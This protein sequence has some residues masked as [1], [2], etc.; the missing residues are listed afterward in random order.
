MFCSCIM[1]IFVLQL[2]RNVRVLSY[3]G[4]L[5][6]VLSYGGVLYIVLS[7]GGVLYI[8]LSYGGVL[9]IVLSY[10]GALRIV[11]SYGGVLYIVLSYGGVLCIV[12]SYGGVLYIVPSYGEVL[13][14]VLS[15][16]ECCPSG[17]SGC[18]RSKGFPQRLAG[19]TQSLTSDYDILGAISPEAA[20]TL[21][22][23]AYNMG[24]LVL[25]SPHDYLN[26]TDITYQRIAPFHWEHGIRNSPSYSQWPT[27]RLTL[28]VKFSPPAIVKRPEHV[29]MTVIVSC[30][31]NMG[32]PLMSKWVSVLYSGISPVRID[33]C[34]VE[35]LFISQI[36]GSWLP[37]RSTGLFLRV[38]IKNMYKPP[39]ERW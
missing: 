13:Y 35:L 24:G 32:I 15:M 23:E 2:K 16:E 26:R 6:I 33:G 22:G 1:I 31:M 30:K 28:Q 38:Q 7:Y 11:L 36:Q 25:S 20:V 21:N 19:C 37:Q 17:G 39:R 18:G 9:Y 5:Y 10:G 27:Q 4:V 3:G 12:M 34:V 14:I 8:V 29:N